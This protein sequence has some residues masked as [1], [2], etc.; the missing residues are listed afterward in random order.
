MPLMADCA[1]PSQKA[2][3]SASAGAPSALVAWATASRARSSKPWSQR[4]P[5]E[6]QPIATMAT[7]SRMP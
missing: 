7:W 1:V 4:S 3:T 6:V 2:S 5:K